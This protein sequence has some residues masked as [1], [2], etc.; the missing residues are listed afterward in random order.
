MPRALCASH[1]HAV[2]ALFWCAAG[3][4]VSCNSHCI[5]AAVNV[6]PL[7]AP[8]A[9]AAA[10]SLYRVTVVPPLWRPHAT[11]TLHWGLSA[12][13]R[14][15]NTPDAAPVR[16]LHYEHCSFVD[17]SPSAVRAQALNHWT[18]QCALRLA[19]LPAVFVLVHLCTAGGA[20]GR[21]PR[22]A[23]RL[24]HR[25]RGQ[26]DWRR[27]V[28]F[29]LYDVSAHQ[30][31]A[32]AAAVAAVAA[33]ATGPTAAVAAIAAAVARAAATAIAAAATATA[34]ALR[35]RHTGHRRLPAAQMVPNRCTAAWV[36]GGRCIATRLE[37]K[38]NPPP[39]E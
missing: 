22:R 21:A 7:P 25:R 13:T 2:R 23:A 27:C 4:H 39:P 15:V 6:A 18:G 36:A 20:V 11:I 26:R 14:A 33:T 30:L 5:A 10:A 16:A 28:A 35:R 38:P 29:H 9:P 34:G 24:L 17:R 32:H 1:A 31:A 37:R 19:H 3:A 12:E 8:A